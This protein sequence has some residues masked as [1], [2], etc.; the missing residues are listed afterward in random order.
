MG[1]TLISIVTC[2]INRLDFHCDEF[3]QFAFVRQLREN[4]VNIISADAAAV[5]KPQLAA[6]SLAEYCDARTT[7]SY[8][9]DTR[10][11]SDIKVGFPA[12]GDIRHIFENLVLVRIQPYRTADNGSSFY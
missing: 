11:S 3:F 10:F 2:R 4:P 5:G 9:R 7:D 1:L 12:K 8:R 6:P